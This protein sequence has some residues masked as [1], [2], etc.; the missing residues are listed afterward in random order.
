[1]KIV[2]I[3][4]NPEIVEAISLCFQLRWAEA[5]V[6][7][8][9]EGVSG[10]EMVQTCYP[11]IVVLD[12]GLPDI[13]GFEVCRRIRLFSDVP[14][15]LL[16][17]KGEEF[18]K[19][20]ALDLGA[21]DYMTK[22]FSHVELLARLKTVLRRSAMPQ[23]NAA[24]ESLTIG[25]LWIDFSTHRVVMNGQTVKLTPIE[26]GLLDILARNAGKAVSARIL[27][28]KVWGGDY[29]DSPDY[30]N[31]YIRRLREKLGDNPQNSTI[32][33]SEDGKSYKLVSPLAHDLVQDPFTSTLG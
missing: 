19:V 31:V 32:I 11:D 1:M 7:S 6:I 30:L 4:D 18:D 2:I 3:E 21:D 23:P 16:T 8:A 20:R 14:I 22:P 13:D 9:I 25:N 29:V 26:Y 17:A 27:L 10:V 24:E 12:I 15:L 28:Q 5:K 33:V